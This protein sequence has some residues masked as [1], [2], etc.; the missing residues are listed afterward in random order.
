MRKQADKVVYSPS[1]LTGFMESPCASW[2]ER[3]K[4]VEPS[5]GE[6]KDRPDPLLNL[7]QKKGIAHEDEF[8][9]QLELAETNI[10]TIPNISQTIIKKLKILLPT[11]KVQGEIVTK[12][13]KEQKLVDSNKELIVLYEENIKATL[14]RI[15]DTSA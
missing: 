10:S 12:I 14:N 2:M 7:L 9:S 4:L 5:V 11:L 13:E 15:W 6:L 1:D 8:T 3:K